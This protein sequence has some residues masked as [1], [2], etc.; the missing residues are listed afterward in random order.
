[1]LQDKIEWWQAG[2]SQP[3]GATGKEEVAEHLM[4][5]EGKAN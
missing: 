2:N 3:G 4:H 5:T 1:M